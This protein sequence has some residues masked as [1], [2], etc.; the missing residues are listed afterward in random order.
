MAQSWGLFMSKSCDSPQTLLAQGQSEQAD[1]QNDRGSGA[2]PV[3]SISSVGGQVREQDNEPGLGASLSRR[4]RPSQNEAAHLVLA[5]GRLANQA[6]RT[7]ESG[8]SFAPPNQ[9]AI[10]EYLADMLASLETL[11]Q[12]NRLDVLGLM[13]AMAREQAGDDARRKRS[14]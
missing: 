10:A 5:S 14:F 7:A 6:D 2:C 9:Q 8:I 12:R 11:A 13:I 4:C 3:A 1:D